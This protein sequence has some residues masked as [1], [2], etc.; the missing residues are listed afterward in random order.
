M[1]D[2][3]IITRDE[4]LNLPYCLAALQGWT[5]QVFVVDSGSTDGTQDI[6]RRMGATVVHHDWE[7]YARQKNWGLDHLPFR[8]PWIL[9]VDADEVVT[10]K[11]RDQ[12]T[13]ILTK[14][15]E[16]VRE[17]GFFLNR[18]T[19]FLE[20]PIYHSGFY[21]SWNLR[22]FKRGK[23]RYEDRPVHE[24]IIIDDP[25]GFLSEPMVHNDRR[26]LEQYFA[27]HNRYST[28]EAESIMREIAGR[29]YGDA[30]NVPGAT[31]RRRWLKRYILP[32]I[33]LP[34]WWR[35]FYMF[36]LR[37]GFLDGSAGYAFCKF[38]STYDYLLALKLKALRREAARRRPKPSLFVGAKGRAPGA[39]SASFAWAGDKRFAHLLTPGARVMITG[40]SGFIGTNL[41]E[42][43]HGAQAEIVN[44]D[45]ATPR[46]PRHVPFWRQVDLQDADA[47]ARQVREFRPDYFLHL[48]ARTDLNEKQDL[49]GYAANITGVDNVLR[50]LEGV[51]SLKRIIITSTQLV[52][53]LGYVPKNDTDYNAHTAYGQSKVATERLT[54]EWKNPPC[55]WT[56]VRPT[57][58]WG[59]WFDAPYRGFFLTL[60]KGR[61]LHPR[62]ANQQRSFGFVGN[63]VYE[64]LALINAPEEKVSGRM[65]YMADYEPLR[66]RDWAHLI[67]EEMGAPP[68]REVPVP[69]LRAAARVGD[70]MRSFGWKSPP[71]TS[72]RLKNMLSDGVIDMSHVHEVVGPMPYDVTEGVRITVQ[73][74]R[75][76]G[77]IDSAGAS[78]PVRAYQSV[79][80]G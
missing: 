1:V 32:H 9:I 38:I 16:Q 75:E 28:L 4:V 2:V 14:P 5:D 65:F 49:A 71:L 17:N 8:S 78:A 23:G 46:D 76:S 37:C 15:P 66:I 69:L 21:P 57:S 27:K 74:L 35:F 45:S 13:A 67:R 48:A 44:L 80:D 47:L 55:P 54:R 20:S 40:G 61:Y 6:A 43:Y 42:C 25:V 50:A 29:G 53:E 73:W 19:Y 7:G 79:A 22:L 12:I 59:P 58:M 26:G 31:R 62:G 52:C 10:T 68:V 39:P 77:L 24:H 51:N 34:G 33:P 18:V 64:Y 72:F 11:L 41:I 36:V 70:T 3:M 30:V 56:L 63:C 60:A